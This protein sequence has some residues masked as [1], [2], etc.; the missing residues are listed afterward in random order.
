MPR[1]MSERNDSESLCAGG[2]KLLFNGIH[3]AENK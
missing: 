1:R 3:I 2:D